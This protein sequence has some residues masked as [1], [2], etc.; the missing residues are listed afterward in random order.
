MIQVMYNP[1]LMYTSGVVLDTSSVMAQYRVVYTPI[2]LT[3]NWSLLPAAK[4]A[5]LSSPRVKA[6]REVV[7]KVYDVPLDCVTALRLHGH[8]IMNDLSVAHLVSGNYFP[9][10]VCLAERPILLG[11]ALEIELTYCV[12]RLGD[13]R[14][15]CNCS[16]CTCSGFGWI[17]VGNA[18]APVVLDVMCAHCGHRSQDHS[19]LMYD[20][21]MPMLES[22]VDS[23][24]PQRPVKRQKPN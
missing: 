15:A 21:S 17:N 16:D 10:I 8:A 5:V 24:D 9:V 18:R 12:D 20:T 11:D 6:L 13:A 19:R 3:F 7:A 1:R 22:A 2:Q 23:T 14:G 4:P